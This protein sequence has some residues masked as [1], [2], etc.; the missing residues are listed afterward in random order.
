MMVPSKQKSFIFHSGRAHFSSYPGNTSVCLALSN[1]ANDFSIY[2]PTFSKAKKDNVLVFTTEMSETR[3]GGFDVS[4]QIK[5]KV[6][7]KG[8]LDN[9]E[10][11]GGGSKNPMSE[12]IKVF[13]NSHEY[14]S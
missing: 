4:L 9:M 1:V 14:T 12:P 8:P 7:E 11:S 5:K 13:S 3:K 10:K 6:P 2:M